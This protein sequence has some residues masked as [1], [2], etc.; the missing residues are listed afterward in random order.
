VSYSVACKDTDPG[1]VT[2][3]N[4]Q[5]HAVKIL[6]I[7]R[8][9]QMIPAGVDT[10]QEGHPSTQGTIPASASRPGSSSI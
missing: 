5:F 6:L 8:D 4:G 7:Q 9:K 3:I 2:A 10:D 1:D